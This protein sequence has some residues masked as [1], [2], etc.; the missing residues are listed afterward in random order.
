MSLMSNYAVFSNG[1]KR[2]S[3]EGE[4]PVYG[5]NGVLGYADDYNME[6]G[7]IVGRV[8]VYCGSVFLE[9]GKCWVSDNA[10]KAENTGNSNLVFLYYLLKSLKLNERRIGTSQPLLTQGILNSIEVDVPGIVDQGKIADILEGFDNKIALN[11]AINDNLAAERSRSE[12]SSSPDI[13]RGSK[14]SRISVRR[15]ISS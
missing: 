13:K 1:K 14:L 3:S 8:G 15:H 4:Y 9:K 12:T 6:Y 5:G 11:N 10:I 7:V 2:P